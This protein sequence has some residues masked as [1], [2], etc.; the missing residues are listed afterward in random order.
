M[1]AAGSTLDGEQAL[2]LFSAEQGYATPKVDVR[3]VVFRENALLLVKEKSDGRWTLPGGW[4]DVSASP[5]ENV[6]REIAEEAGFQTR[7]VKLLAFYDRE[8]HPHQPPYVQH[9]YKVFM[10]CE[11]VGGEAAPSLETDAVAFF[12]EQDIPELSLARVTP[13]QIA[14]CF[15]HLRQ[16]DLPADFD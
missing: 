12:G 14:R 15:V 11:I 13:A 3:G 16:P 6:T 7:A 1:L 10:R 9:V 2:A 8:K 4:A 5:A